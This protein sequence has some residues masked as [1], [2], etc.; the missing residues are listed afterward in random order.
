MSTTDLLKTLRDETGISVMQCKK[1]LDEAG[2]DMEKARMILKK[3]SGDAAAKKA[4]RELGAGLVVT[5][6][7]SGKTVM[8]TLLCET[9]FVAKND[10]FVNLA[11]TLAGK[12]LEVGKDGLE[13]A[14]TEMM[15]V[16][17]QKLGE[18]I[19][20]GEVYVTD[21]PNAGFYN[22]NGQYAS[23]VVLKENND[24]LARDIAMHATAMRPGFLSEADISDEAKMKANEV[25]QKEVDTQSADKPAEMKAK[26]LEG[27]VN[28]FFKEQILGKQIFIKDPSK[29]IDQLVKEAGNEIISFKIEAL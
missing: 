27:K 7:G 8:M 6:Q 19:K 24:E 20:V 26:I 17:I 1:A 11:K 22:H 23:V 2:G 15:G 3:K 9:D 12:V 18:N 4:D 25:F 21:S 13:A 5:A 29:T 28:A 16:A 14:S 10:D